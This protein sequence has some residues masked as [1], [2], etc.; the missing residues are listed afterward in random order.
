MS[1]DSDAVSHMYSQNDADSL[2]RL[3]NLVFS[4][5]TSYGAQHPQTTQAIENFTATLV[6]LLQKQESVTLLMERESF[7]FDEHL[8]NNRINLRKFTFMF[9]KVGLQ[10]ITF[11]VGVIPEDIK[12]MVALLNNQT[13]YDSVD[14]MTAV[15]KKRNITSIRFNYVFFQK[16]TA[17]DEV[18]KKDEISQS[19]PHNPTNARVQSDLPVNPEQALEKLESVFSLHALVENPDEYVEKIVDSYAGDSRGARTFVLHKLKEVNEQVRHFDENKMKLNPT[20]LMESVYKMKITLHQ[21]LAHQKKMGKILESENELLDEIDTLSFETITNLVKV[22]YQQ[23]THSV[24]RL[25]RIVRR[26][27]PDLSDLK[28]L[29]PLLKKELL[30]AGMPVKDWYELVNELSRELDNDAVVDALNKGAEE[31]GLSSEEIARAIKNSPSEAARLIVLA[32]EIRQGG[33]ADKDNLSRLLTEYIEGVSAKMALDENTEHSAESGKALKTIIYKIEKNLVQR[34][35]EQGI[36]DTMIQDVEKRLAGSFDQTLQKL[37]S[38]WMMSTIA[39]SS[40]VSQEYLLQIMDNLVDRETD[41]SA[42]RNPLRQSLLQKGM[43]PEQA[44]ELFD[45]LHDS[46]KERAVS[47]ALP[48]NVLS[49]HNTVFFLK[50]LIKENLRYE[51]PFSSMLFT[52]EGLSCAGKKRPLKPDERAKVLEL[53]Y[54]TVSKQLRD[55]DILGSIGTLEDAF[56]FIM[57][58]MTNLE[59]ADVVGTRVDKKMRKIAIKTGSQAWKIDFRLSWTS[60]DKLK[61]DNIKG[62]LDLV[63]KN[64]QEK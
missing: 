23:G 34:L 43:T 55:L 61:A 49:P 31:M 26:M 2:A 30:T 32:S 17:D 39:Q 47:G 36:P 22:E 27:M 48:K 56:P 60:F 57:L 44:D 52:I 45:K 51:N 24:K 33:V 29:L 16:V 59:G 25:A 37:K 40:S 6:K 46:R 11:S 7:Y 20:E 28:R 9:Q 64:H 14:V 54:N 18:V 58:P 5:V 21:Q 10:A 38:D 12:C 3:I 42:F 15:L 1:K 53:I 35:Q 8:I 4:N 62:Y 19:L 50:R 13:K 41:I 63:K